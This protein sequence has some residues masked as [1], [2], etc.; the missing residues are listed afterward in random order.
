MEQFKGNYIPLKTITD[1]KRLFDIILKCSATSEKRLMLEADAIPQA[2]GKS[3]TSTILYVKRKNDP[4]DALT[5]IENFVS[6]IECKVQKQ[7]SPPNCTICSLWQI[8]LY[9]WIRKLRQCKY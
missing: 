3:E 5:K 8:S 2:Y 1:S 7:F 9:S 4:A 6:L